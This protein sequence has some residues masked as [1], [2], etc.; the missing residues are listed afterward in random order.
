MVIIRTIFRFIVFVI[1]IGA[2]VLI[3]GAG[4]WAFTNQDKDT[5]ASIS[6]GDSSVI[7][8]PQNVE[9]FVLSLY[10][11]SQSEIINTAVS[12]DPSPVPFRVDIGE[13]AATV[14]DKLSEQQL[15]TDPDIFRLFLRYN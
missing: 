7:R 15:I 13:N 14:A 1:A 2:I 8:S 10:L 5:A 12:D 6:L 4:F 9:E 11:Q 3:L